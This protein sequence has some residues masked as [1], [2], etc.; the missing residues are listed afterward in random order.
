[1]KKEKR[2]R[3]VT[4][5]QGRKGKRKVVSTFHSNTGRFKKR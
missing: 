3:E 1:M 5:K 2:A 4:G